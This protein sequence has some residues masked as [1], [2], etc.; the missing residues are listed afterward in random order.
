VTTDDGY[1]LMLFHVS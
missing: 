1:N